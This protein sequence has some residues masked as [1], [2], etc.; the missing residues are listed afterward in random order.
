MMR[1][2]GT[3]RYVLIAAGGTGG[4]VIPAIEVAKAL[5]QR[6]WE[7]VFIGTPHGFENRLV[8]AAGFALRQGAGG[9]LKRVSARRRLRTLLSAPCAVGAMVN[10]LQRRRPAAALS[11][12]GYSSGPL[13]AACALLDVPLVLLEPNACPGLANRLAAPAARRALLGRPEAAAFFRAGSCSVTGLPVRREF[14][15]V[16]ARRTEEPFSI[17]ILGGSQGAA[18]LNRAALDAAAIWLRE[19]R[20]A[21]RVLHQTGAREHEAVQEEYRKLGFAAQT[22]AFFDEMPTWFDEA[23][24]VIC[25][26]GASVLAELCAAR[27]PS[28][29]VPFPFAADD[30]QTANARS[31][32]AAGGALLVADSDWTG[33]RMAREVAAF[34]RDRARLAAMAAA[35]GPLARADAAESVADAVVETAR[36]AGG[37]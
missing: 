35:L 6:G 23:D 18:R 14:F 2:Q 4:H 8:P 33:A 19:G 20:N 3:E 28:V 13:V 12:G 30:H 29:L 17:L 16:G 32:A 22:A 31:L 1:A 11:L 36:S 34:D 25:R 5:R 10:L 37:V 15:Q 26:A 9:S 27:K 24:L 21:P 7:C